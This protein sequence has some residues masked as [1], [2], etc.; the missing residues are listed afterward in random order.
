[1]NQP[2]R[3]ATKPSAAIMRG[4]RAVLLMLAFLPRWALADDVVKPIK[5]ERLLPWAIDAYDLALLHEALERTQPDYGAYEVQPLTEHVSSARAIQLAI[6]GR[7]VNLYPAGVGQPAP[8]QE[9]ISVPFPIDKGL[10]AYRVSL[11]DRHSQGRL[12]HVHSIEELR[13]L[14][15]GQGNRWADVRIYE[16]NKIPV[17]TADYDSLF[18]MLLHGRFDL[19]PRGL[20]EISL[21]LPAHG[22]RYPDLAVE[23]HLL[24]HY[25]FCKVYYVSRSAPRLAARLTVGLERMVQ[26]GSFDAVFAKHYG[27]VL[28]DLDLPR[29]AVI[30]L[31]N[32]FLPAWVPRQRKELWFD[33]A[34]LP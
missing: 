28:A 13:Q 32:P 23:Q 17:E 1:L 4:L 27:K 31:E 15:V 9:M 33:P 12:S 14:R 22:Q 26:D 20:F 34:R 18:P 10:L 19:F 7:L 6:E 21:E 29:R 16:H 8:E 5:S 25:P 24:L 11:I 2:P 3:N 30:E